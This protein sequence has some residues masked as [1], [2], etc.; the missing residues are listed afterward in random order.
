METLQELQQSGSR[1]LPD[2]GAAQALRVLENQLD[3]ASLEHNEASSVQLAYQHLAERLRAETA[4]AEA[5]L[6]QLQESLNAKDPE[7]RTLNKQWETV[8][9]ARAAAES[10]L[11]LLQGRLEAQREQHRKELSSQKAAVIHMMD[12]NRLTMAK[13]RT[14]PCRTGCFFWLTE[15]MIEVPTHCTH[16]MQVRAA[17]EQVA[18]F[19]QPTASTSTEEKAAR[20]ELTPRAAWDMLQDVLQVGS[21][22]QLRSVPLMQQE[23]H[24]ALVDMQEAGQQELA[25]VQRRLQTVEVRVPVPLLEGVS[26]LYR[27]HPPCTS[28]HDANIACAGRRSCCQAHR[29]QSQSEQ[30]T[31]QQRSRC[32]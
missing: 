24:A 28:S 19:Q 1:R 7:L 16:C 10:N 6:V 12:A 9:Q 29:C 27:E 25:R 2:A 32:T 20:V 22:E 3:K 15:C 13:A 31:R 23:T 17:A 5:S 8:S 14:V 21:L 18:A 11:T 30:K 4:A 26:E